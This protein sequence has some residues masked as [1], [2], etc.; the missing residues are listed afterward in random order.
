MIEAEEIGE[1][2]VLT[3]DVGV[4]GLVEG[5]FV[6]GRE[7]GNA[8]RDHFF[9]CGATATVNVFCKHIDLIYC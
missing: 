9:Q 5:R 4:V 8:L 6:V 2:A 7:E 3:I 1:V